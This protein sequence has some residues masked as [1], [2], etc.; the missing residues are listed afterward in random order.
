MVKGRST[1]LE[2]SLAQLEEYQS[3]MQQLR[4]KIIQ[5]EQHLRVV[6]AP[7]YMPHDRDAAVS[8][9]QVC[10]F[11]LILRALFFF[12]NSSL[13]Y[14]RHFRFKTISSLYPTKPKPKKGKQTN[15]VHFIITLSVSNTVC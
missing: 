2:K 1:E 6:L 9:Q 3:Q 11:V 15:F 10:E 14:S 4:Q 8:E 12:L 7:T 5:E 13:D